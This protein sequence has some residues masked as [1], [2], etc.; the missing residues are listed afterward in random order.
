MLKSRVIFLCLFIIII[1]SELIIFK[2]VIKIMSMSIMN[3]V[4]FFNFIVEKKFL[5]CCYYS[6][7]FMLWWLMVF[8]V[9]CKILIFF[10][11]VLE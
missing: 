11:G 9:L 5:F 6:L 2:D 8:K 4:F 7:M 10:M 1:K 3:N